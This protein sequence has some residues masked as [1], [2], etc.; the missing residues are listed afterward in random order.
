M[1]QGTPVV[2][3]ANELSAAD[4]VSIVERSAGMYDRL[5]HG[6]EAV[7]SPDA[8]EAR[9]RRLA[10]WQEVVAAGD[11]T[12]FQRRLEWDGL[13]PADV[14]RMLGEVRLVERIKVPAWADLLMELCR[15]ATPEAAVHAS[16][17]C[18]NPQEPVAFEGATIV[19]VATASSLLRARCGKPLQYFLDAAMAGLERA[20]LRRLHLFVGETLYLE[21]SLWRS[22]HL[23]SLDLLWMQM[24]EEPSDEV[25]Q[26]FLAHMLDGGFR[27]LWLEYPV[28]GRLVAVAVESWIDATAELA[29]RFAADAAVLAGEWS[30]DVPLRVSAVEGLLS[31]SHH[32][33][34]TVSILTL[35]SG[36]RV[37]YKPRSVANEAA[38]F[39]VLEWL[40]ERG[41]PHPFVSLN[42]VDRATYGWMEFIAA[43]PVEDA[44]AAERFYFRCGALLALSYVVGVNDLHFENLI[45]AGEQPVLVDLET[46]LCHSPIQTIYGTATEDILRTVFF[47]SVLR[48]GLLPR[49]QTGIGSAVDVSGLGAVAAQRSRIP[50]PQWKN[51]NNDLMGLVYET[52]EGSAFTNAAS[53]N[54]VVLSPND[55][56]PQISEGFS[57]LYR[58][59]AA[60]R[61]ALLVPGGPLDAVSGLRVRFIFRATAS[62]LTTM[63]ASRR[64]HLLRNG[65]D[66]SLQLEALTAPL[67]VSQQRPAG[68]PLL[69]IEREAMEIED[70]PHFMASVTSS[71]IEAKPEEITGL[72]EAACFGQMVE[73]VRRL[74]PKDL[75]NQMGLVQASFDSRS[76]A[77]VHAGP[78]PLHFE[79]RAPETAAALSPAQLLEEAIKIADGILAMSIAARGKAA[80]WITLRHLSGIGKNQLDPIGSDLF[81][82]RAG[83]ALMLASLFRV[84]G[85]KRFGEA[86]RLMAQAIRDELA[87]LDPRFV[88]VEISQHGLSGI[89]GLAYVYPHLA[90]LLEMPEF[91]Q[92]AHLAAQFLTS[93]TA[94]ADQRYDVLSGSAGSILSLLQLGSGDALEIA[95]RVADHLLRSRVESEAG[96]L[97][98]KTFEDRAISGQAHGN[99]GIALA[100]LRLAKVLPEA[101]FRDAA[102]EAIAFEDLSFSEAHGNWPDLRW[103]ARSFA[104][105]WCHGA[106]GMALSRIEAWEQTA[107]PHF[108]NSVESAA[109][110]IE[111]HMGEG[112]D[113]LCCGNFGRALLLSTLGTRMGR[114]DW[115]RQSLEMASALSRRAAENG[116]YRFM[117]AYRGYV[118]FPGL[119]QG[120][121][122]VC[123]GL[124]RLGFPK[125]VPSV[126]DLQ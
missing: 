22:K 101:R 7:P 16:R 33:G 117:R 114:E 66:H 56:L 44:G 53:L 12:R 65:V 79:P 80:N 55:Y 70:C 26:S 123:M 92:D 32:H 20:L 59:L 41:F 109:R 104:G 57:A 54:G 108:A 34:R 62:Y 46:I 93:E 60:E 50:V 58:S 78:R 102:L 51:L 21:F 106:P 38:W 103:E 87:P 85:E 126:I 113:H 99:A 100:L 105:G 84:S 14:K 111:Q 95:V 61:E 11:E 83:I 8:D 110:V 3:A 31:D 118:T 75:E 81:E 48:T 98:W 97:C 28:L 36:Q 37:V 47:E 115:G 94:L 69:Q 121:S 125:T 6:F 42:I 107:D 40:T 13:G 122:G 86:A 90:E 2:E 9:A 39:H 1:L 72:L 91:L 71:N 88:P 24:N 119:F 25:Y 124:L 77:T 89:A 27:E 64:P 10:T 17:L 73:R 43:K 82:G 30:P 35:G 63:K 23:S 29:E 45:A 4:I 116:T 5:S 76:E 19:I 52:V 18:V 67:L 15:E 49:W 112:A 120:T 68:W 96:L 74:G